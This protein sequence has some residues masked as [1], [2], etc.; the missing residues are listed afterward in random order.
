MDW[1]QTPKTKS[2]R[3]ISLYLFQLPYTAQK[4]IIHQVTTMLATY[5]DTLIITRAPYLMVY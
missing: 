2:I 4:A 3:N 5:L 1:K